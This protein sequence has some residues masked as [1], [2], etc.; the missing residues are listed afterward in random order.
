MSELISAQRLCLLYRPIYTRP[1]A[2]KKLCGNRAV[3][4]LKVTFQL[5]VPP[6]PLA[7]AITKPDS[8]RFRI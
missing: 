7:L 8:L 4:R 1:V 2:R 5:M 6:V 3:Q